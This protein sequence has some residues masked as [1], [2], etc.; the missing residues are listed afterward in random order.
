MLMRRLTL[1]VISLAAMLG[2]VAQTSTYDEYSIKAHRYFGFEEWATAG[3]LYSILISERPEAVDNYSHAIVA[4]GML[5]DTLQQVNI[6]HLALTNRLNI[7][8]LF[9]YTER[10]SFEVGQTSLY[11]DYL[12]LVR[13]DTPWL[14]RVINGYLL[15]YYSYRAYGP[16]IVEYST[17][18][19]EGAPLD[20]RFMLSL[21]RGYLL[22]GDTSKAIDTYLKVIELNPS[23][24]RALLYVGNY[25]RQFT[26]PASRSAARAYLQAAY[27]IHPTPYIE[28]AL[29]QLQ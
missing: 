4:A 10:T 29:R 7:D 19:L 20:E 1:I 26:D 28:E 9:T 18:M 14:A 22:C 27:R 2:A 5:G 15:R 24:Y 12:L 25:Y 21:A 6:T 16:G 8:S 3:A 17:R 13:A 23:N 11:E